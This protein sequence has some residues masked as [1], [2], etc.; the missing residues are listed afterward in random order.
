MQ[1][2]LDHETVS[3]TSLIMSIFGDAISHR[4]ACISLASLIDMVADFGFN[5]RFVR[6]SVFRLGKDGWLSSERIG[7]LS[8]YRMTEQGFRR[9]REAENRIYVM[10]QK[11]WDGYW[12]LVLL[13]SVELEAKA[14][15]KRSWGGWAALPSP[16]I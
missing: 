12:D 7:R 10:E 13:S 5:E 8:F 15:L 9:L 16:P 1:Q 4:G 11:P 6:T 2:A 14:Q 3:G